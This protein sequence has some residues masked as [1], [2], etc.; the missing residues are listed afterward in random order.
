TPSGP[1]HKVSDTQQQTLPN[2]NN[3]QGTFTK[4]ETN[5]VNINM[6]ANKDPIFEGEIKVISKEAFLKNITV[7][8]RHLS[9]LIDNQRQDNNVL[10]VDNSGIIPDSQS[11]RDTLSIPET[12]T[13]NSTLL[14][15]GNF[16]D[17]AI[18]T[19]VIPEVQL[20]VQVSCLSKFFLQHEDV[21]IATL[22]NIYHSKS[23]SWQITL[24]SILAL[25]KN[26]NGT[27][28][29]QWLQHLEDAVARDI[30]APEIFEPQKVTTD[31]PLSVECALAGFLA[32]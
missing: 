20:P 27:S 8:N 13:S 9:L 32:S 28:I 23:S 29:S 10:T 18:N 4:S 26:R 2:L 24:G 5:P 21:L 22:G 17:L 12:P 7:A 14:N 19:N 15:T 16:S 30:I 6:E 3:Y 1:S 11:I 25:V 31:N